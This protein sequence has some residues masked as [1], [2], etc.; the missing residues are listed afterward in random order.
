MN[1]DDEKTKAARGPVTNTN[2]PPIVK[3]HEWTGVVKAN[4][5]DNQTANMAVPSIV[6]PKFFAV[7]LRGLEM[8]EPASSVLNA[9][10]IDEHT[11]DDEEEEDI[12][13]IQVSGEQ[14]YINQIEDLANAYTHFRGAA[15]GSYMPCLLDRCSMTQWIDY[16][17]CENFTDVC[18]PNHE[19]VE[20]RWMLDHKN[21]VESFLRQTI[22][23]SSPQ[24]LQFICSMSDPKCICHSL[25]D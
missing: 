7:P 18:K 5:D 22:I 24:V 14:L 21:C 11:D 4:I 23:A 20:N 3:P 9:Q 1:L 16:F 17:T 25:H 19:A 8:D 10:V 2:I 6:K 12:H 13:A 15:L